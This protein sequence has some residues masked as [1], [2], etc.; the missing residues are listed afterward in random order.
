MSS[1]ETS[2]LPG[3]H[4]SPD[5]QNHPDTYE[6]ENEAVDPDR[7][8]ESVMASIAPWEDRIVLDLGAGTG[9][10]IQRF[11]ET[12]RHVIAVEPDDGLRLRAMARAAR[13]NTD[14]VSVMTGSAERLLLADDSVDIVHARFAYFFGP[15][16]EPG[17][18]ELERVIQPGGA[19]F[20]IDNDMRNGTFASWIARSPYCAHLDVDAVEAFWTAQGFTMTR[21]MSEWRFKSRVDLEAVIRIE[22]PDELAGEILD[23]HEG[24]SVDYGYCLYHK[25]Y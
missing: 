5:I 23:G 17:L 6:I 20:I 22:F 1:N 12:A 24:V 9:Y 21:I 8:I 19:A 15:G 16:C 13:L 7:K 3:V 11:H 4:A 18:R 14:R 2:W 10:F 25:T